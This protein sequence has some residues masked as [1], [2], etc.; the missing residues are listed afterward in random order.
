MQLAQVAAGVGYL[1]ARGFVHAD[2]RGVIDSGFTE[3]LSHN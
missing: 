2:I 1:H 3:H